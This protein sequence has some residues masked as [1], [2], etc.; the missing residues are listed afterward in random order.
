MQKISNFTAP[1][2]T[3]LST[4]LINAQLT[5]TESVDTVHCI[6][7]EFILNVA[8]NKT[9][10]E[11][12]SDEDDENYDEHE[13]LLNKVHQLKI[14]KQ[15]LKDK[16]KFVKE[17]KKQ[18]KKQQKQQLKDEKI[19]S[20]KETKELKADNRRLNIEK[21]QAQERVTRKVEF[22]YIKDNQEGASVRYKRNKGLISKI[23]WFDRLTGS[24]SCL[25]SINKK[26]KF[27]KFSNAVIKENDG[28]NTKHTT[29]S[30]EN[31]YLT[32]DCGSHLIEKS[33]A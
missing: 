20:K 33:I 14:N 8:N 4:R 24:Q 31:C 30:E 16:I 10:E 28:L 22:E 23:K 9:P 29:N 3:V 12:T 5:T 19:L 6:S 15:K 18:K 13:P 17:K 25:L 32:D 27:T 21:K 11:V 2:S 26:L 1:I 7:D